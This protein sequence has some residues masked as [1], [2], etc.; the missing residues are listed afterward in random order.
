M[1]CRS[2]NRAHRKLCDRLKSGEE[3]GGKR[4]RSM[5]PGATISQAH[6]TATYHV[7][8]SSEQRTLY[9]LYL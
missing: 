2:G 6:H 8:E 5:T 7:C 4:R 1:L 9:C 3:T